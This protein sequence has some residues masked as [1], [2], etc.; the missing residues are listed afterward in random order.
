MQAVGAAGDSIYR[1]HNN[2]QIGG[3]SDVWL[4]ARSLPATCSRTY[5]NTRASSRQTVAR[6]QV[7]SIGVE[8]AFR[9]GEAC[10]APTRKFCTFALGRLL[11]V[12]GWRF[13]FLS[14]ADR[15]SKYLHCPP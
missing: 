2:V 15:R 12:T 11:T 8:K 4:H 10:L 14:I 9:R 1:P 7:W 3:G 6:S 5:G 13:P